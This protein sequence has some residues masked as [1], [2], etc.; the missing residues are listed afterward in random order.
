MAFPTASHEKKE[1]TL[2]NDLKLRFPRPAKEWLEAFP[3]GCGRLGAMVFGGAARERLQL[4]EDTLWGGG[5]HCYDNPE[6]LHHLP[7][8]R[9]LVFEGK[10][11]EAERMANDCFMGIPTSQMMYQTA[12]SL[13]LDFTNVSEPL[14]YRRELDIDAAMVTVEFESNGVRFHREIFASYPHQVIVVRLE[15]DRP[16]SVSFL[17]HYETPLSAI[18]H[19]T[20]DGS[21]LLEGVNAESQGI[22]PLLRFASIAKAI[23]DGGE[24]KADNGVLI[25]SGADSVT[26]LISIA[27]SYVNY[28]DVSGDAEEKA[29][30][31]ITN[32]EHLSYAELRKAHLQDYRGLFRR[33]YFD[34]GEPNPS[35]APTD[36]RIRDFQD[37]PDPQLIKLYY[38]FGRYLLISS[39]RPGGQSANLQGVWNESM[40]PPWGSKYTININTE[41]NYWPAAP[42]NLME[43]YGP[44]FDMLADL[45]ISGAR[46]AKTQY[47][48]NGWVC[49]HNT[50]LW[51]GT[52]PVDGAGPGMWPSGGSWLCKSLWD[53]YEFTGDLELLR[54]HYP[55]IKGAAEFFLDTLMEE[56]T[57]HWLVTCPSVSPEHAH[58]GGASICAGPTMDMQILRDLFEACVQASELFQVD[59]YFRKRALD[60]RARLAPMQI[61]KEGQLQEWLEDWDA[62]A[63]DIH[64]RHVSHLYGLYPSNQI[65]P[66]GTPDLAAAAITTL[67]MRGDESTGWSLAWKVNLWARLEDGE[68]A[69][70]L[71][72]HLLTPDRTAPNLFDLHPPFQIDGNFG[73]TSGITE[74]LLQSHTDS[75]HLL[76]AIP[77]VWSKGEVRGLRARGGFEVDMIWSEG[78]LVEAKIRS[79]LGHDLR[80]RYKEPVTVREGNHIQS[81]SH[82][83]ENVTMLPTHADRVYTI[84][85]GV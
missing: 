84:R 57:H 42:C 66:R 18:P 25:V 35:P 3:I 69:Y 20:P 51:R 11:R 62:D 45:Q 43:C 4:N 19:P 50:E 9:Q 77:A 53:H 49:H 64:H 75:V 85:T 6:A 28:T 78:N 79:L 52:A 61:G 73:A 24:I 7:Q 48:A 34:L 13:F 23:S 5:P 21:L 38:Q 36:E 60:A 67:R 76:P 72:N 8:I 2:W 82:P 29:R 41:M 56:P 30:E 17:T 58:P 27:T 15:A 44:L 14:H 55:I 33:V 68:H 47:D 83:E 70:R 71:I 63:P 39:S 22:P 31:Y 65:T 26:L 74:M 32:A 1:E 37:S 81:T 59:K 16:K 12:G 40:S 46:T 10:Y 54:K 80:I